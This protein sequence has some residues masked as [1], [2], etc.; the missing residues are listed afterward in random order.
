VS[1]RTLPNESK[2]SSL[3]LGILLNS[4]SRTFPSDENPEPEEQAQDH[5]DGLDFLDSQVLK[6][7][8]EEAD[9]KDKIEE[10]KE[11]AGMSLAWLLQDI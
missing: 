3:R 10:A 8:K 2:S 1:L 5:F 11:I 4:N 9:K 7:E 6:R